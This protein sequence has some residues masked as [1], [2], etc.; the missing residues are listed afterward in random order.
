MKMPEKLV[1]VI[2]LELANLETQ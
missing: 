1:L 2:I